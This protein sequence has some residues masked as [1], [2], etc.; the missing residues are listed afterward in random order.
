MSADKKTVSIRAVL[1]RLAHWSFI[2][3]CLAYAVW[4]L[5]VKL[6]LSIAAGYKWTAIVIA[7]A[8]TLCALVT[9]ARRLYVLWQ[10][11]IPFR[12]I[13]TGSIIG[14]G[15]NNILPA[16][17]GEAVKAYYLARE[18]NKPISS[19]LG[20]VFWERFFDLNA[21]MLL[22]LVIVYSVSSPFS[23]G[24]FFLFVLAIW[25]A[26]LAIR[27]WPAVARK[28][29]QWLPIEVVR[30]FAQEL[31][32]QLLRRLEMSVVFR[33]SIWTAL[34]WLIYVSQVAVIFLWAAQLEI[35]LVAVLV[36]FVVASIG[37]NL[38]GSPGGLGVFEAAIVASAS[39][40]G[41]GR[42]EALAAAIVLHVIQFV[43]TTAIAL[44]LMSQVDISFK[45]A[46]EQ[47]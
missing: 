42:E 9:L 13:L 8:L 25:I 47:A 14:Q 30:K 28:M 2:I 16:K 19:I 38:A 46:K 29:V 35:S 40:F 11:A 21:L 33:A 18:S 39:W 43:P 32:E 10:G 27:Q 12:Q 37:M 7:T 3:L 41:V 15:T 44:I 1:A 24:A 34:L 23:M 5:D 4:G 45:Q 20:L 31:V 22:G 26:L 6:F 36:I 17:L